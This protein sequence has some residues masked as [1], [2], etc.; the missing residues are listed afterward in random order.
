[1]FRAR[2]AHGAVFLFLCYDNIRRHSDSIV[3]SFGHDC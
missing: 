1:M 2:P 3:I